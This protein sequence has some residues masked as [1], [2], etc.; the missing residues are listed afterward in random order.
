MEVP[1]FDSDAPIVIPPNRSV[2]NVVPTSIGHRVRGFMPDRFLDVLPREPDG[3]PIAE[4]A[5]IRDPDREVGSTE[6]FTR[7]F[8]QLHGTHLHVAHGKLCKAQSQRAERGNRENEAGKIQS[9][10]GDPVRMRHK[11]FVLREARNAG[12]VP[13]QARRIVRQT[14]ER[15]PR[16]MPRAPTGIS[17][18]V[19]AA[20]PD[21]ALRLKRDGQEKQCEP[22]MQILG[23]ITAVLPVDSMLFENCE[24]VDLRPDARRI[25][26]KDIDA[27]RDIHPVARRRGSTAPDRR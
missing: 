18:N 19:A 2:R 3:K 13:V 20:V 14:D 23:L 7:P 4:R 5:R 25:D 6:V 16:A 15:T 22:A 17:R 26:L 11:R 24:P 10:P 21:L 12:D 27:E 1:K 8:R 9:R